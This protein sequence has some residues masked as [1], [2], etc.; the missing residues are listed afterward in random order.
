MLTH[1]GIGAD[2]LQQERGRKPS[3][4]RAA[5]DKALGQD[6]PCNLQ[7]TEGFKNTHNSTDCKD[8]NSRGV[9]GPTTCW[10]WAR[11][12]S[13]GV[14]SLSERGRRTRD[15]GVGVEG[16]DGGRFRPEC[17]GGLITVLI[18]TQEHCSR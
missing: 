7:E 6:R 16:G 14:I 9:Q 1:L 15:G 11:T 3:H 8:K 2:S 12:V 13:T 17:L 4:V 18:L 10:R 5:Q